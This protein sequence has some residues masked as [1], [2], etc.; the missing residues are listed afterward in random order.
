MAIER[1]EFYLTP[2]LKALETNGEMHRSR[3]TGLVAEALG[4]A[5]EDRVRVNARGT[6]LFASR[7]H[8]AVAYLVQAKAVERHIRGHM[9]ITDRGR[10]LLA[11]FPNGFTRDVFREYPDYANAWGRG[12]RVE[13]QSEGDASNGDTPPQE[14]IE[15]A[16]DEIEN[17]LSAE[18]VA[19]VQ[20]AS[21]AFLEK[22]TLRLMRAM[23]YGDSDD[24]LEHLGGPG[25]GGVDGVIKQDSLGLRRVY[26]QAKRYQDKGTIGRPAIQSFVGA[27]TDVGADGGVFV[28]TASFTPDAWAYA[29]R[30]TDPRVVLIDGAELGRLLVRYGIGVQVLRTYQVA[31]L[32]EEFFEE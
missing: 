31:T 26:I 32:D 12:N 24:A 5:D 6:R 25:D 2:V 7:V 20:A 29:N 22:L 27:I 21:P 28:T 15:S 16:I 1:F 14:A 30:Q 3:I 4:V 17:Q 10:D 23:G 8:W 13:N 19:R 18:L 11:R 9:R